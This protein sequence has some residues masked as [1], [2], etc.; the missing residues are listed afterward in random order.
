MRQAGFLLV[1]LVA[2]ALTGCSR[3]S[4][5]PSSQ[6]AS[7]STD[8]TQKLTVEA[9]PPEAAP[10]PGARR[11][12][13]VLDPGHGG[14]EVGTAAFGLV[15]KDSNLDMAFRVKS[16]LEAAG[17]GVVLTRHDDHRANWS[18]DSPQPTAGVITLRPVTTL[19]PVR[20]AANPQSRLFRFRFRARR[21]PLVRQ[22]C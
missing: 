11:K 15:E 20:P 12:V 2:L 5:K 16:L 21:F 6:A 7:Q 8:V 1:V 19:Q 4:A 10:T 14:D 13:V 3:P 22:S 18:P 17:V 9:T